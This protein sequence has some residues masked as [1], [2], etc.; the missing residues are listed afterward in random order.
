M[1]DRPSGDFGRHLRE[2]RERRGI[3]LRQIANSTKIGMSALEALERDDISRLP[4]GIFS[5]AF[6]RSY[7]VEVGLDPEATIQRFMAQF[8]HDSITAGHPTSARPEDHQAFEGERQAAA[9]FVRLI[10][11]S[12]PVA[13][14]LIY[15]GIAGR[16]VPAP[17]PE[18]SPVAAIAP[19][20]E[21]VSAAPAFAI[22]LPPVAPTNGTADRLTVSLSALRECWISVTIDGVSAFTAL[23]R[24]GDERSIDVPHD[25]QLTAGDASALVIRLNGVEAK[26]LGGQ[27]E[28][29]TTRLT[30]DNFRDYLLIP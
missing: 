22:P 20:V 11:L 5:R 1:A 14:A 28:V 27:G 13:V 26:P 4:G 3:S 21:P 9:T 25:L 30:L 16:S 12:L 2:A 15:F 7:A 24:P 29:V 8:P 18:A 6:V 23:L 19:V 10:A 17:V